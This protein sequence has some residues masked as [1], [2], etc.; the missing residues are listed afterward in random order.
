MIKDCGEGN[1]KGQ[2]LWVVKEREKA[3]TNKGKN[4]K[5]IETVITWYFIEKFM[6]LCWDGPNLQKETIVCN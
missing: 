3:A 2:L 6:V 1:L 4:K 5:E